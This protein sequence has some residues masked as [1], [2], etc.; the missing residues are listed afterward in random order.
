MTKRTVVAQT[1]DA[2]RKDQL[3]PK[4]S[5]ERIALEMD[6]RIRGLIFNSI[7]TCVNC[8]HFECSSSY[9]MADICKVYNARPPA[10]V[11]VAGCDKHEWNDQIPF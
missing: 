4:V 11:I 7:R 9:K 10:T 8:E 6:E 3:S 1:L 5:I 2:I